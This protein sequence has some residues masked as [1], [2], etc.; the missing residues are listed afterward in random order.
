VPVS[1]ETYMKTGGNP[2]IKAACGQL[3]FLLNG[4]LPI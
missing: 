4:V 1:L 2:E 3:L